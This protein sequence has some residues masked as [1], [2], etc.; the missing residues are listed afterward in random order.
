MMARD[1]KL[2]MSLNLKDNASKL[3]A[4]LLKE[5][6]KQASEAEKATKRQSEEQQKSTKAAISL[7]RTRAAELRRNARAREALGISSEQTIRRQID[8]TIAAYNRLTRAGVMSAT[9]Q[10]RAFNQMRSRVAALRSELQGVTRLERARQTGRNVMTVAGGVAAAGAAL[11]QPIRKQM[12]YSE[13]L[14][15]MTNTAFSDQDIAGRTAG[16]QRLDKLIRQ[17]VQSSGLSKEGVMDAANELLANGLSE[18]EVNA[19]LP[20]ITRSASAGKTDPVQLAKIATSALQSFKIPKEQMGRA[21]DMILAAGQAGGFEQSDMAKWLPAQMAAGSNIGMSGLD[22]LKKILGLN[23]VS[24]TTAGSKD[25]AGNNVVNLLA[26]IGSQDAARAAAR[27]RINGKGI[28]LPG[29]LAKARENGMDPLQAFAGVINKVVG[30]DKRYQKLQKELEKLPKGDKTGRDKTLDAMLAILKGA[31]LGKIVADRQAL[32]ALTAYMNG[33][34]YVKRVNTEI[35]KQQY[36]KPGEKSATDL[37]FEFNSQQP[38]YK[39]DQAKNAWDFA[40]MDAVK[41][42]A[43]LVGTFAGGLADAA[44]K[45]PGLATAVAGATTA[46]QAM[47][48]A[49]WAMAGLK[50]LSSLTGGAAKTVTTAATTTA[51]GGWLSRTTGTAG[52]GLLGRVLGK[53]FAPIAAYEGAEDEPLIQVERAKDK[54]ARVEAAGY[55]LPEGFSSPGLLD[56]WDEWFGKNAP[57]RDTV[58]PSQVLSVTDPRRHI[59]GLGSNQYPSQPQ[60]IELNNKT[61]LEVD[62]QTLAEVVNRYNVQDAARGTGAG[63]GQ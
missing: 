4:S 37:N 58:A 9:E 23:E 22:G 5:G 12:S 42:P 39:A 35:E 55:K 60:K 56:V 28:D 17:N 31:G 46:I 29:T 40:Q 50:L 26:K 13:R 34:D 33:G 32:M 21:M 24:V 53:L 10:S 54:R 49:A 2:S 57:A 61:V 18:K 8:Q 62:G 19:L 16:M 41:G 14:T 6:T 45:F 44:E 36:R 47:T 20:S 25:E 38:W 51:E 30:Q 7:E 15:E 11:V 3:L 27:I 63:G 59:S 43:H 48:Q 52:R 1:F